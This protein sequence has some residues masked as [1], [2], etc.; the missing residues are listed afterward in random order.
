MNIALLTR[1]EP[2]TLLRGTKLLLEL[3]LSCWYELRDLDRAIWMQSV[4]D[5]VLD[6]HVVRWQ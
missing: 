1:F 2:K 6:D 4:V 5:L 3:T